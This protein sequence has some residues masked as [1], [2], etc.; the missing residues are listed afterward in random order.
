M[1]MLKQSLL[2]ATVFCG[3]YACND[4]STE[5]TEE[6]QTE[7]M[8][9]ETEVIEE[10][11]DE[12]SMNHGGGK[13]TM[14]PGDGTDVLPVPEGARVYFANLK[15]G[16]KVNSPVLI[17]FGVEGMEVEPAGQ[18]MQNKGHHHIQID[19]GYIERGQVVPTS[20][21]SIH[22]GKGQTKTELEL[23]PGKHTLTMQFADGMHQSYGEQM[24]AT[25]TVIV[26]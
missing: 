22:F 2:I 4:A 21:T 1:K 19:G 17:E 5:S 24:S 12:G 7:L 26:E 18:L 13:H 8:D 16:Q 10:D 25:I 15:D 14:T 23:T 3:L 9:K 20:E 6:N 11:M